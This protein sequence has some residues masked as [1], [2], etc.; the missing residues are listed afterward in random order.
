MKLSVENVDVK[1]G[2]KVIVKNVSLEV[3]KNKTIGL[4]GAN[5]SG[6]TTLLKSIY[7]STAVS[8]GSVYLDDLDILKASN[9][10]VAK[11]LGVVGQFNDL[12]FDLTVKQIVI[13]GRTPHKKLLE[14]DSAE[15]YQIVH[16]ALE[17]TQLLAYEN[18]SY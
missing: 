6:K 15:D 9:K 8:S 12:N 3:P 1:L 5:G 11:Y 18:R 2:K 7:K 14:S 10:E 4:I 13:L 17:K 16:E